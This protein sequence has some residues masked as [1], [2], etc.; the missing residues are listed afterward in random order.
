MLSIFDILSNESLEK[1]LTN[2]T[3]EKLENNI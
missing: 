2:V 1:V 3:P